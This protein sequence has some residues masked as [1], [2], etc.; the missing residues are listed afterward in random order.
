L[1]YVAGGTA[2][3]QQVLETHRDVSFT[4]HEEAKAWNRALA[5]LW[6]NANCP[7]AE[8]FEKRAEQN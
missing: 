3:F 5:L 8:L 2:Y 6:R 7:D 4:T 1:K